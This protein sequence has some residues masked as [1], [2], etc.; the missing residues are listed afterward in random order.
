MTWTFADVLESARAM[1]DRD[2]DWRS[3]SLSMSYDTNAGW[4]YDLHAVE[5]MGHI[6]R[7]E[8]IFSVGTYEDLVNK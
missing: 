4:F 8:T 7:F 2:Y 6:E 5:L 1:L 3:A